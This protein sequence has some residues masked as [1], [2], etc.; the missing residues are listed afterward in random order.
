[1]P[2][3]PSCRN[4][5]IAN[6]LTGFYMRATLTFNGLIENDHSSEELFSMRIIVKSI[7]NLGFYGLG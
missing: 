5:S 2:V 6:Q 1:M 4:Q 3:F 7:V